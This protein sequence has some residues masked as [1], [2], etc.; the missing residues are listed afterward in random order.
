MK[1]IREEGERGSSPIFLR[2]LRPANDLHPCVVYARPL[3]ELV[4]EY[5]SV[6][7]EDVQGPVEVLLAHLTIARVVV[8]ETVPPLLLAGVRVKVDEGGVVA[9]LRM[10]K[11][12]MIKI[13]R[14]KLK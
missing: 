6:E 12:S 2:L 10:K 3:R 9:R 14:L 13:G 8:V 7:V 1:R 5:A 4:E 11:Y